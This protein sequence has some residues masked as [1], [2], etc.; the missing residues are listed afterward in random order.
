M[1]RGTTYILYDLAGNATKN[2][3]WSPNVWKIRIILNYKNI[4]HKT[5]WVEFPTIATVAQRIG[6]PHTVL[7]RGGRP[8]YTVP[9]L[10]DPETERCLSGSLQIA[11]NLERMYPDAPTLFPHGTEEAII[12][13]NAKF[14][15]T[16]ARAL[17]KLLV[18]RTWAQ[19]NEESKDYFRTTRERLFGQPLETLAPPG[20]LA[21]ARWAA[22]REALEPFAKDADARGQ[23]DTFLFGERETYADV[24][25]VGWLGW[26]RRTWGADTQEWAE[27]ETWH[28]GRWGRLMRAF[29]KWEYVDTPSALDVAKL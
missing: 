11:L 19:L 6:A 9:I 26:A 25:A 1:S 27:L 17:A 8:L 2:Q 29:K 10:R 28:G 3:A 18:A 13:F 15:P 22:V 20:P 5:E 7:R 23:S 21:A 24:V 14:V 4:P 16:V 12:A